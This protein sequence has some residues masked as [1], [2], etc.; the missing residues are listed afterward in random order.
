ML[1]VA[2][3]L[4]ACHRVPSAPSPATR[5]DFASIRDQLA[6]DIRHELR[7]HNL[8]GLIPLALGPLSEMGFECTQIE[9]RRVLPAVFDGE[10]MQI[11]EKLPAAALP[12]SVSRWT[13]RYRP[14]LLADE[15]SA[16]AEQGECGFF[17][18]AGRLWAEFQL[19]PAFGGT[20]VRALLP[21]LSETSWR[22]VG[23]LVDSGPLVRLQSDGSAEPRF[24]YSGWTFERI[25][26]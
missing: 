21:P 24:H 23:P 19:L 16:L 10:R 26:E 20:K 25:G 18:V 14:Q 22:T 6:T 2:R 12:M 7:R 8:A 15:I 5:G 3:L 17:E 11:G 1:G 13:G 4:A 9:G